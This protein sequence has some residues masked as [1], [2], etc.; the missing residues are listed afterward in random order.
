MQGTG[1]RLVDAAGGYTVGAWQ[2]P[3]SHTR[4]CARQAAP[5]DVKAAAICW[6]AHQTTAHASQQAGQLSPH[7]Q[8][9]TPWIP[10]PFA[11]MM[12]ETAS[13]TAG[14]VVNPG[15]AAAAQVNRQPGWCGTS[16]GDRASQ[17]RRPDAAA[18][19]P[20]QA[21]CTCSTRHRK[22][23]RPPRHHRH[24]PRCPLLAAGWGSPW[25][26]GLQQTAVVN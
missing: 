23:H 15:Q 9:A 8:R 18:A 16:T 10:N 17:Q 4:W 2:Q 13:C 1:G 6:C 5:H 7:G 3:H 19:G 14:A 12:V 21:G 26:S 11:A 25:P 20:H 24:H 22:R